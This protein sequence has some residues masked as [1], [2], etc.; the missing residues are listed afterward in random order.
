M[1]G[2]NADDDYVESP[3]KAERASKEDMGGVG[4]AASALDSLT[5]ELGEHRLVMQQQTSVI[6]QQANATDN[7]KSIA[8][9]QLLLASLLDSYPR[10]Q[11]LIDLIFND[12]MGRGI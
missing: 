12:V 2:D 5:T 6:Q 1:R 3:S 8:Q 7:K 9:K 11:A 4:A 10:K